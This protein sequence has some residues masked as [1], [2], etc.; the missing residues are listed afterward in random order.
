MTAYRTVTVDGLNV[1]YR[2]AGS[3]DAPTLMLLHRLAL[4]PAHR[5]RSLQPG[6]RR[7]ATGPRGLS[8]RG[9]SMRAD[10]VP[11]G[12]SPD[13]E[14]ADQDGIPR[15]LSALQDG[16][17][18]ILVLTRGHFCPRTTSSTTSSSNYC[19]GSTSPIRAW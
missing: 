11:G 15:R 3:S 18:M 19:Q 1:F 7:P 5:H 2:E 14:L 17:P 8:P 16:D 13:Y 4:H 10:I 6:L 12:L 9:D